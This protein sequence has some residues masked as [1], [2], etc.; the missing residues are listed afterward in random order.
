MAAQVI[1]TQFQFKRG[2]KE[3]WER[4]N[5]ILANG[6]PGW[7]Y[8]EGIFK[9]GNGEDPWNQLETIQG[10]NDGIDKSELDKKIDKEEFEESK[11][12]E[13]AVDLNLVDPVAADDE[14]LYTDENG[15]V[16]SF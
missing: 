9:I 13:I 3:A 1:T 11:A 10:S 2:T 14:T 8:D 16:Y 4:N 12:I 5:P 6:E 7:A 15:V